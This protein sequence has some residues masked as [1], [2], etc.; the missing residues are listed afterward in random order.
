MSAYEGEWYWK[1]L[2]DCFTGF[3][4]YGVFHFVGCVHVYTLFRVKSPPDIC[5]C[6]DKQ[7]LTVDTH[8]G[9][10]ILSYLFFQMTSL[11]PWTER[12][13]M[14]K[15]RSQADTGKCQTDQ[16]Y[17]KFTVRYPYNPISQYI[18]GMHDPYSFIQSFIFCNC[19]ILVMNVLDLEPNL[20]RLGMRHLQIPICTPIHS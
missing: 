9:L 8:C 10:K 5:S 20:G 3:V 15:W 1:Y 17:K 7:E 14:K 19:F 11:W 12:T 16:W 6:W 4:G 18:S 2:E 13:H